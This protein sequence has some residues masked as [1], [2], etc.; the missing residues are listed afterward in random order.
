MPENAAYNEPR[1]FM[2]LLQILLIVQ[3]AAAA[4][5]GSV[6]LISVTAGH[7]LL[8]P[9]ILFESFKA[10]QQVCTFIG[11]PLLIIMMI[12]LY[13]INKN[14]H[15][16]T[17]K[18][19]EFSPGWAVGWWFIPFASLVQP[20]RVVAELYNANRNPENWRKNIPV[21]LG[22][23]W[24]LTIAGTLLGAG[25]TVARLS[26]DNIPQAVSAITLL[27]LALHQLL[28]LMIYTKIGRWQRRARLSP[29]LEAVS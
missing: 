23:W 20:L 11:L 4:F 13:R 6:V 9:P 12:W 2:R 10:S 27:N 26:H 22:L 8:L 14:T 29:A 17:P 15:A 28:A 19:M 3:T 24:T 1:I 16:L 18:A 25:V 5:V 7:K 21:L